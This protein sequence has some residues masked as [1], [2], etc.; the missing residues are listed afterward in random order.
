M[1][2]KIINKVINNYNKDNKKVVKFLMKYSNNKIKIKKQLIIKEIKRV[3]NQHIL[4]IILDKMKMKMKNK[5]MKMY[6][7]VDRYQTVVDKVLV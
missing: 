4:L 2:N 7:K 6:Q 5:I 1:K 3:V